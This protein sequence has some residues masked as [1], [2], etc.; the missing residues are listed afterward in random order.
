MTELLPVLDNRYGKLVPVASGGRIA[1][2]NLLTTAGNQVSSRAV[3]LVPR[4]AT[5]IQVMLAGFYTSATPAETDLPNSVPINMGIEL[6]VAAPWVAT[7][8]YAIGDQVS[9]GQGQWTALVA[10][11]GSAPLASN[12]NWTTKATGRIVP[13]TVNGSLAATV[14]AV[15]TP[16]GATIAQALYRTDEVPVNVAAGSYIAINATILATSGQVNALGLATRPLLGEFYQSSASVTDRS[17]TGAIFTAGVN[18]ALPVA[19]IVGRPKVSGPTA[20]IIGDSRASGIAARTIAPGTAAAIVSGGAGY[21]ANDVG[22]V[23]TM[24]DTNAGAFAVA[25]SAQFM[26]TAVS[27]GAVTQA[28]CVNPGSYNNPAINAGGGVLPSGTQVLVGSATGSGLSITPSFSGG[29]DP[30]GSHL[31][32]GLDDLGIPWVGISRASDTLA[33]WATRRYSRLQYIKQT[34]VS[35]VIFA[36]GINDIAA[37][38]ATMQANALLIANDIMSLGTVSALLICTLDPYTTSNDG[39][40][41]TGNQAVTANEANRVAYNNWA[42]TLPAPFTA[43]ID[44]ADTCETARNSGFWKNNGGS[45]QMTPDGLHKSPPGNLIAKV[46]VVAAAASFL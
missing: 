10:N 8:A 14:P 5:T 41:T 17:Q 37:G 21:V 43:V 12:T 32:Q 42:R 28:I 34:G 11:T 22:K 27:A 16:A 9:Y 30:A 31:C 18:A 33:E 1:G 29:F 3:Y 7:K 20:G 44:V 40:Q 26:I 23:L 46:P 13:V 2:D 38:L 6:N 45:C 39:F 36:L 15:L 24:P 4:G 19:A 25:V 35:S